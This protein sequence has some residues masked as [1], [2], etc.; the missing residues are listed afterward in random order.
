MRQGQNVNGEA[1]LFWDLAFQLQTLGFRQP[2]TSRVSEARHDS[3]D[4]G[5]DGKHLRVDRIH[6]DALG[7]LTCHA[8]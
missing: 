6:R 5:I 4:V 3:P 2:T 7:S 1:K 8:R